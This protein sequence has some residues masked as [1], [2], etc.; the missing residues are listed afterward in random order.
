MAPDN[1]TIIIPRMHKLALFLVFTLTLGCGLSGESQN[2]RQPSGSGNGETGPELDNQT[3]AAVDNNSILIGIERINGE[4]VPANAEVA[5]VRLDQN[6]EETLG[7]L[8]GDDQTPSNI[9]RTSAG[10]YELTFNVPYAEQPN[11]AFRVRI[12]NSEIYYAPMYNEELFSEKIKVDI[13]S[14]YVMTKLFDTVNSDDELKELTSCI[15][16][17]DCEYQPESKAEY[18]GEIV[19]AAQQYEIEVDPNHSITDALAALDSRPDFVHHITSAVAEITRVEAPF[20]KATK[21]N[22]PF[23]LNTQNILNNLLQ[24]QASNSALFGLSFSD[25]DP[26]NIN[27]STIG[28]SA[29]SSRKLPS[30]SQSNSN[31]TTIYPLLTHNFTLFD[32]RKSSSSVEIPYIRTDLIIRKNLEFDLVRGRSE[33]KEKIF[34]T[35]PNTSFLSTQ[36]SLLTPRAIIDFEDTSSENQWQ[37]E[38]MLNKLYKANSNEVS[39]D[40]P[41]NVDDQDQFIY[42]EVDY[43]T[44]PTWL[45]AANVSKAAKYD[46]EDSDESNNELTRVETLEDTNFFSWEIHSLE[47]DENFSSDDIEGKQYNVIS[48][49]LKLNETNETVKV[50]AETFNWNAASTISVSQ[51][52]GYSTNVLVRNNNNTVSGVSIESNTFDTSRSYNVNPDQTDKTTG[53]LSLDGG[54]EA[55]FGH[56]TQNGAY[57]AF[58]FDT[59]EVNNDEDRG[60][61]LI[62]AT[63]RFNVPNSLFQTESIYQIQG[64]SFGIT[65]AKNTLMNFNGSTLTLRTGTGGQDCNASFSYK[66]TYIDHMVDVNFN[67]LTEMQTANG[68][69]SDSSSCEISNNTITLNF[70]NVFG[71]ALELEGFISRPDDSNENAGNL[72]SFLWKQSDNLGLIFASREQELSPTF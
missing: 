25:A 64:N 37:F 66:Q 43:G 3:G 15:D 23:E 27:S 46:V 49:S 41:D 7:S 32:R 2:G 56:S 24:T 26:E 1:R 52:T 50:Y 69:V 70:I 4:A 45:T 40:L 14:H 58:T 44:E 68:S 17:I 39:S 28:I 13:F 54:T 35:F 33:Y 36:G 34:S 65:S 60:A 12:N 10:N 6:M 29:Y 57:L 31:A 61:G 51:P 19:K 22:Y 59:T 48:Y 63:E 21:R 30:S 20:S 72:I 8:T 53:T 11:V 42:P 5:V 9:I 67:R 71:Q 16:E 62:I 47:T 55:A 38:P 18:L